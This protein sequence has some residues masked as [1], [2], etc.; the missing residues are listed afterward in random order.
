MNCVTE[1]CISYHNI[2]LML[3]SCRFHLELDTS[4]EIQPDCGGLYK[5]KTGIKLK[6]YSAA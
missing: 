5:S 4:H 1:F 6:L 2:H 3:F